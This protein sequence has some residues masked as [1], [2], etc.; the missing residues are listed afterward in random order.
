MGPV[1]LVED[2]EV[3]MEILALDKGNDQEQERGGAGGPR[4]GRHGAEC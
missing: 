3:V 2:L 4:F 1:P